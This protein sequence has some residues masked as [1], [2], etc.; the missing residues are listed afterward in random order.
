[1]PHFEFVW[2]DANIEHLSDNGIEPADAESVVIDPDSIFRS[3]R[4][5]RRGVRGALRD[6]RRIAVIYE[7]IDEL[8]VFVVTAYNIDRGD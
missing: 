6:G 1:M 3:K 2:T 4:T 5:G 7:Q 8:T